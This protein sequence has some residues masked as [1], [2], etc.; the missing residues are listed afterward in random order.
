MHKDSRMSRPLKTAADWFQHDVDASSDPKV[1]YLEAIFGHKGYS[2]FFKFLEHMGRAQNFKLPWNEIQES[3]FARIFR[4]SREELLNF[5][6]EATRP[7]VGAFLLKDGF[8]YSEGLLKRLQPLV[9]KRK[10]NRTRQGVSKNCDNNDNTDEFLSQ[11]P[12]HKK[13]EFDSTV[14]YSTVE[15]SKVEKSTN[16][17]YREIID[18]LNS[19]TGKKFRPSSEKSRR[20]IRARWKEGYQKD[21]FFKVIDNKVAK[22]LND[23]K[24]SD[25][26]RPETLFS[27][28][29][30]SY[31]NE[32]GTRNLNPAE[33]LTFKNAQAATAFIT[34]DDYG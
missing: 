31:I 1:E 12:C 30:E 11:K 26:L 7:E 3:I 23:P 5:V 17:P 15:K 9:N 22:W 16:I 19:A 28:K 20:L 21:D 33:E 29:F 24:F 2:L 14:Q 18:Y 32:S 25:F 13:Q 34:G 6:S 4:V 10:Y 27:T 8:L